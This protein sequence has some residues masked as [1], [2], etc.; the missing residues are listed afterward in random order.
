MYSIETLFLTEQ[1]KS[2][3]ALKE[4]KTILVVIGKTGVTSGIILSL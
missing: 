2:C 1:F 4:E 3:V